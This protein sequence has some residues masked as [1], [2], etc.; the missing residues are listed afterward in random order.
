VA[1]QVF[2]GLARWLDVF[3]AYDRLASADPLAGLAQTLTALSLW[4]LVPVALGFAR[5]L[6]REVA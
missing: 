5:C 1:T 6:R 2:H 4:V 3:V